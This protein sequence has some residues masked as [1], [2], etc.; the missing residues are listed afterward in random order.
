MTTINANSTGLVETPDTSGV[1][2][3]QTNGS[4]ALAIGTDQTATFNSTSAVVVPVGT[5]AQRHSSPTNGMIRYNTDAGKGLEAYV[6]G[7]WQIVKSSGIIITYNAIGG[8]SGNSW[9]TGGSAGQFSAG[10]LIVNPGTSLTMT[11]GGG[12]ASGSGGGNTTISALVTA[13]GGAAGGNSGNGYAI[14]SGDGTAAGGGGGSS[15]VGYNGGS[16]AGGAGGDG[17]VSAINGTTYAGGGGG[18]GQNGGGAGKAGGGNGGYSSAGLGTGGGSN[19][20]ANT[21]SGA[22]GGGQ[23]SGG[24]IGSYSGGSGLILISVATANYTGVYTGSPTISTSGSNT[25]L[26]F[27]SSGTYTV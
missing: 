2:Q 24:F 4:N 10:T 5:T 27:T 13:V 20:S 16:S 26:K 18:S 19:A 7:S 21:G 12:G 9:T 15:H 3:F 22:G 23:F 1:L 11:I 25:I 17:T 6:A 8:G 14:G